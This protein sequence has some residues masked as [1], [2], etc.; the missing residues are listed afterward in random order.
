[1]FRHQCGINEQCSETRF[2]TH[3]LAVVNQ[4]CVHHLYV[5]QVQ[6]RVNVYLSLCIRLHTGERV[7]F[8]VKDE[9]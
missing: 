8:V 5:V 2:M 1:M 6:E 4:Q 9:T 7:E 3:S